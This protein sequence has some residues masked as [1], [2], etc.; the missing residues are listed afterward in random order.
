MR[1]NLARLFLRSLRA[2]F[3]RVGTLDGRLA[4]RLGTLRPSSL[5]SNWV[6]HVST[7]DPARTASIAVVQRSSSVESLTVAST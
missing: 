1:A 4:A 6:R 2:I 3:E 7:Y 5:D